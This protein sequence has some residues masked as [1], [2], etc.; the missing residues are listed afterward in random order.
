MKLTRLILISLG[1][2]LFASSCAY[3]DSYLDAKL[4][5]NMAYFA[6]LKD[7]SRTVVVGEGMQFRIGAAMAGALHND[8]DRTVNFKIGTMP[9]ALSDTSHV[10]MP[11]DYYNNGSL[12]SSDG[13]IQ[14][15][16]PKGSFIGY[17]P[18]ILDSVKFLNDP[19]SLK[20]KYTIPVKIVST[21]LDSINK[22]NDSIMVRV[23]YMAGTEG[24]YLYKNVITKELNGATVGQLTENYA[25]ESND[26]AW[27]MVTLSP[28]SV[29]VTA[30]IAE[31][32]TSMKLTGAS[33]STPLKFNLTVNSSG[34]TYQQASGQAVIQADGTSSY[35][36][37]THDFNLKFS[38]KKPS[39]DTVYHVTSN[40]IFRNR[41]VDGINQTRA[42]LNQLNQ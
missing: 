24:Y 28:F 35:D 18:I 5:K 3:D 17:F 10:L 38:F 8:Y 36:K 6:S 15:I 7:Y 12:L 31:Y 27:Q 22:S 33:V 29:L 30:P 34:V 26:Q 11:T 39:N 13:T 25:N 4:P 32:S 14:A 21:S 23:K 37:K 41:M 40:L 20:G 2:V 19:L 42:Y 9:F 1:F 16:I